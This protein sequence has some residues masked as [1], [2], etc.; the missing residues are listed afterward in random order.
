M[1]NK[2]EINDQIQK[3]NDQIL[4]DYPVQDDAWPS[5]RWKEDGSD[6]RDL[7]GFHD[8]EVEGEPEQKA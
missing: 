7:S 8:E 1:E 6:Y 5:R 3:T 2:K 4:K